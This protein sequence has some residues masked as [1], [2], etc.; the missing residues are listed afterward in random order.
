LTY[1]HP[2]GVGTTTLK[3]NTVQT[4]K[5]EPPMDTTVLGRGYAF[6]TDEAL[7]TGLK[8]IQFELDIRAERR[9][10][11]RLA[12]ERAAERAAE[13]RDL[14]DSVNAG[15]SVYDVESEGL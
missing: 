8:E 9:E 5:P 14:I 15:E 10:V 1:R 3:G 11:S 6:A 4:M 12:K 2:L 13:V 7:K